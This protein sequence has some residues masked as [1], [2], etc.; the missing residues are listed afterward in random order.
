MDAS[1]RPS[2]TDEQMDNKRDDPMTQHTPVGAPGSEHAL[3]RRTLL[4]RTAAAAT[5]ALLAGGPRLMKTAE[6]A[7]PTSPPP[8]TAGADLKPLDASQTIFGAME[9]F[10]L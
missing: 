10:L 8:A 5:L 6:A 2:T 9:R 1:D 7:P 3:S 4:R